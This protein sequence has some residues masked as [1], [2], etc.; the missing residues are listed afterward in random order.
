ME[1]LS[2][3]CE[4][5]HSFGRIEQNRTG[6]C[7]RGEAYTRSYILSGLA[8][9]LALT[10]DSH[11]MVPNLLLELRSLGRGWESQAYVWSNFAQVQTNRHHHCRYLS[12]EYPMFNPSARSTLQG[13]PG[14][15]KNQ[16][17][18]VCMFQPM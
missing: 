12:S 3:L 1:W 6:G 2:C 17:T 4:Y 9:G 11:N 16:T 14:M 10:R 15:H 13:L 8:F 5:P 18:M 7:G